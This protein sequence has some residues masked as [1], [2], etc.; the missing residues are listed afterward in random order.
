MK[1]GNALKK[2][3]SIFFSALIWGS[4]QFFLTKQRIKGALFF[5]AQML[6][7]GLEFFT[8]Y[9]WEWLTGA[10]PKFSFRLHGGLFTKGIWGIITLGEKTG[11]IHGDHSTMLMING[12]VAIMLLLIF[13]AIYIVNIRDAWKSALLPENTVS[14]LSEKEYLTKLIHKNFPILVLLPILFIFAFII[15][16]PIIFTVLTAFTNYNSSHLPPGNLLSWTGL[17]NFKKLFTVPIWSASFLKVS[18]WTVVWAVS[19][20]L[21]TF[22]LGMIQAIIINHPAVKL[23]GF[24]R[25]LLILP[26]AMPAM[27][28]LLVFRNLLNG[29]FGPINEFLIRMGIIQE[30]IPFLSDPFVSR[31]VVVAVNLW[32]SFPVYMVMMTGILSNQ[33]PSLLEA[34][35]IDGADKF[36]GFRFITF[37]LLL[38]A[39]APLLVITFAGNFNAFG[40]IFFLTG[41]GPANPTMQFA[42]DT[43]ILISWVYKLTLDQQMYNMAAV[44]STLLFIL[45]GAVSFWNLRRTASF[46]EL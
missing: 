42:G 7:I 46:K 21:T 8:G 15:L 31:I 11:G 4:G 14:R 35:S 9:W 34:S 39:V 25:T 17:D 36:Q 29:Q 43:D 30:R 16:M 18:A 45:V 3:V 20:T 37:P 28:S 2:W 6:L 27:I 41:G 40:P 26:W 10:I 5:L 32:L 44:M 22:L 33:D 12:V 13:L 24:F 23:K 1:G 38:K 19:T